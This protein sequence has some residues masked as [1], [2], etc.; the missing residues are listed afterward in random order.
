MQDTSL[1]NGCCGL[2]F[3]THSV[4]EE[5]EEVKKMFVLEGFL[6]IDFCRVSLICFFFDDTHKYL[7]LN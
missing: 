1:N 4:K 5:L 3:L 6:D 7:L 2:R